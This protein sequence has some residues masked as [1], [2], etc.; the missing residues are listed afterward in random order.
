MN[1]KLRLFTALLFVLV[2][3]A[4]GAPQRLEIP[5]TVVVRETQVVE[6]QVVAP[7]LLPPTEAPAGIGEAGGA[8]AGNPALPAATAPA[9][10]KESA[11][12]T[13]SPL[14]YA[15]SGSQMVIKDA[16]MELLVRDT[17]VAIAQVTQM[18]ADY[19]GYIISSQTWYTDGFKYAS[20]RLGLPSA[21]FE[22]ALNY[23][24]GIG[25]QVLR[26]NASGQDVSAEYVDLQSR[27]TN[28]EATAARVR[29]FLKD[30]KTVEESLRINQQ[31]S[32][33][34][35]QIEQVK[36]QMR[37]YEGRAAFSTVTVQLTPQYPT[38]TPS[39]TPTATF[40]PTPTATSTPTTTPSPT[41]AW[42][43]GQTFNQASGVMVDMTQTIVDGLIWVF[44]V[45]GPFV[46]IAGLIFV[47][48]RRVFRKR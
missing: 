11:P 6:A 33:L 12:G 41:P 8:E 25:L 21:G 35:A 5:A 48:A 44:V 40:T 18:A 46:L 34:E 7:T 23:L 15:P 29:D 24:R 22:K 13:A 19:Q 45:A 36:G 17:D 38:P 2:L 3:T 14:A 27:L 42:N 16:E 26:E 1:A 39:L 10:D 20:L 31:L 28:L 9:G 32:D 47:V 37:Y 43:P 30:A 4:C